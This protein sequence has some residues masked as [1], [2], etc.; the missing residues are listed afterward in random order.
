[1]SDYVVWLN[2][3]IIFFKIRSN[4]EF[5]IFMNTLIPFMILS[6]CCYQ[7]EDDQ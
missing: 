1:M 5:T 3:V 7:V 2:N 6:S 4:I